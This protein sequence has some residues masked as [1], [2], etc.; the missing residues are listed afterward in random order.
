[1][2]VSYGGDSITFADNS[3]IS[4]GWTGFKNRVING[5]MVIDQRNNGASTTGSNT[6][7]FSSDRWASFEDSDGVLTLQRSSQA[8]T[9]F[10]NS[11]V[12]TTT[13]ADSSLASNQRAVIVH[14]I[15]GYNIADLKWGTAQA[16]PVTLSFWV[17]CSLTGT[18]GG[19]LTNTA[20]AYPFTYTISNADTWEYKTITIPGDTSGTFGTRLEPVN[21]KV[22][23]L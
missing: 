6:L 11:I 19:T 18:F 13:T 10:A 2:S 15:E 5:G 16:Q 23:Y 22:K 7:V 20:R 17:R 14:R 4:S 8:P 3:T 1:M 12:A 21:R 9:G